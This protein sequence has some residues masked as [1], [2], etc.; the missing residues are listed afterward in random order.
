VSSRLTGLAID[1]DMGT[2]ARKLV[3]IALADAAEPDGTRIFPS[4]ARM[5][6]AALCS[7]KTVQREI[8]VMEAAGLLRLVAEAERYRPREYAIDLDVLAEVAAGGFK[9]VCG[10]PRNA[11]VRV[12]SVSPLPETRVDISDPQGGHPDVHQGGHPDVPQTL[13][14]PPIGPVEREARARDPDFG[15]GSEQPKADEHPHADH[16]RPWERDQAFLDG[17]KSWG[18]IDSLASSW[19]QWQ[20]LSAE[21]RA[22]ALR[23]IPGYLAKHRT[24]N[25]RCAFSTYLGERQFALIDDPE[26]EGK[27]AQFA[28]L[29]LRSAHWWTVLFA[30]A[31]RG[32]K[33]TSMAR[34]GKSGKGITVPLEEFPSDADVA[35]MVKIPVWAERDRCPSPEF[36]AWAH[37]LQ[38]RCRVFVSAFDVLSGQWIWVPSEY[39]QPEQAEGSEAVANGGKDTGNTIP[40]DEV[41]L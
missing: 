10:R 4:K 19:R 41:G 29:P 35:A 28:E 22:A 34:F 9:E 39:P 31:V 23:R 14:D 11:D 21:D 32:E 13:P 20:K 1:A 26:A 37:W 25:V 16:P 3:L 24:R 2:R 15:K 27:P 17:A 12:D 33:I 8:R 18:T 6:R 5:A 36:S 40:P 7:T 38:E 30:R